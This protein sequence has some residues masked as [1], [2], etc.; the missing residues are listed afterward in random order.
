MEHQPV[1][2]RKWLVD[3]II[4]QGEKGDT[5]P[6]SVAFPKAMLQRIDRIAKAT[7]NN[8]SDAIRHLLRWALDTYEKAR[9]DER[10]ANDPAA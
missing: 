7:G 9:E 8:R 6:L 2:W 5:R 1:D 10:R 3:P 4:P